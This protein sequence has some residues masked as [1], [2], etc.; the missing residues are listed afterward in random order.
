MLSSSITSNTAMRGGGIAID[1]GEFTMQLGTINDNGAEYGGAVFLSAGTCFMTALQMMNN[2][3]P[4]PLYGES[5]YAFFGAIFQLGCP[6]NGT[7]IF[8]PPV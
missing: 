6:N 2:K 4:D 1:G 8:G 7:V 5:V 3:A